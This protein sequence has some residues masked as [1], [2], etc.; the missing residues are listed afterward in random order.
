MG[1]KIRNVN[2][3]IVAIRIKKKISHWSKKNFEYPHSTGNCPNKKWQFQFSWHLCVKIISL[4]RFTCWLWVIK[5]R[6]I[7][8][9]F[10]FLGKTSFL[11]SWFFLL[12]I[13]DICHI[14]VSLLFIKNQV[15]CFIATWPF[16]KSL[17][18]CLL[19]V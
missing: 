13:K 17:F 7:C 11:N 12:P 18:Y 2:E 1:K 19:H 6:I 4:I 8:Y 14:E 3:I 16:I 15:T 10:E 5:K 9:F